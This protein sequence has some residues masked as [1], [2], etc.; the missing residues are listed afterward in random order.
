ME[1]TNVLPIIMWSG[2]FVWGL[3]VL[4]FMIVITKMTF[5]K[6]QEDSTALKAITKVTDP[7]LDEMI[8]RLDYT[9]VDKLNIDIQ[10][11]M[12]IFNWLKELELYHKLC[13]PLD[14]V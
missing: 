1:A 2:F 11:Q 8:H 6:N 12:H 9:P 10:D 13:G 4:L 7:E 5:E 3:S 14:K